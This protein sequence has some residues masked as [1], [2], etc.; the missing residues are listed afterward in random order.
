[1]IINFNVIRYWKILD[2]HDLLHQSNPFKP[3]QYLKVAKRLLYLPTFDLQDQS[4]K[5]SFLSIT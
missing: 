5:H 4:L 2:F 3:A 1:M